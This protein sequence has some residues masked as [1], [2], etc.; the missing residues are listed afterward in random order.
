MYS[1]RKDGIEIKSREKKE[2]DQDNAYST[3]VPG[4]ISPLHIIPRRNRSLSCPPSVLEQQKDKQGEK[5]FLFQKRIM[6]GIAFFDRNAY[7]LADTGIVMTPTVTK[8]RKEPLKPISEEPTQY[9]L[10]EDQL[11]G[12]SAM[13]RNQ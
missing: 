1:K 10:E 5:S 12:S 4:D 11:T 9:D 2:Q 7:E 6:P 3:S 8:P 13:Q